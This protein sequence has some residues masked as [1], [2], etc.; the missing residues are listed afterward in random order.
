[1]KALNNDK[2]LILKAA[3]QAQ[4]AADF[5]LNHKAAAPREEVRLLLH[6]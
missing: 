4:A 5:I 1:L 6:A 2:S 3:S